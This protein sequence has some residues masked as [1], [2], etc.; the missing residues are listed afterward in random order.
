MLNYRWFTPA[1]IAQ[2]HVL[3]LEGG[4]LEDWGFRLLTGVATFIFDFRGLTLVLVHCCRRRTAKSRLSHHWAFP[5][6]FNRV[7]SAV[8]QH[9]D[10]ALD[11]AFRFVIIVAL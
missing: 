9:G 7:S 4:W 11:G 3:P 8:A 10:R 6:V 2:A 1:R 5:T